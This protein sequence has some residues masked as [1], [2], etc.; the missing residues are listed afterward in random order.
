[1]GIVFLALLFA[2]GLGVFGALVLLLLGAFYNTTGR[3]QVEVEPVEQN[4]STL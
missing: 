2:V 1:L 3:L 4:A